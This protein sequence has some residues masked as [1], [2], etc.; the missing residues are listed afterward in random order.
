MS[1]YAVVVD[2]IVENLVE[3]D[4]ES[5]WKPEEGEAILTDGFVDIGWLYDGKKFTPASDIE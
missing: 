5:D 3:W 1:T 4:G 2:G